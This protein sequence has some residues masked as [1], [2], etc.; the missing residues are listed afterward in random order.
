MCCM[1]YVLIVL[2]VNRTANTNLVR[3]GSVESVISLNRSPIH[4]PECKHRSFIL[5]NRQLE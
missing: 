3:V 5:E 2:C 1:Y 4:H